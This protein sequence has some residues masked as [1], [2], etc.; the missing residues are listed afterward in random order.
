MRAVV[1]SA[2]VVCIPYP[3]IT[4]DDFTGVLNAF[5]NPASSYQWY[6]DGTLIS[7]GSTQVHIPDHA[8]TYTVRVT[9]LEGCV[10]SSESFLI[11][12][13]TELEDSPASLHFFPNPA[14]DFLIV[15]KPQRENVR[16]FLMDALGR[17][18]M[19]VQIVRDLQEIELTVLPAGIYTIMAKTS[20]GVTS[21]KLVK[22]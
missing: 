13:V 7:D 10:S 20:S 1:E 3:Y 15:E 6:V 14:K 18:V 5:P 21:W 2:D 8:G 16:L 17:N 12:P 4:Q 22:N 11:S 19:E 9:D